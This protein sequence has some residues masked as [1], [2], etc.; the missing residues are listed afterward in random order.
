MTKKVKNL[1]YSSLAYRQNS[2]S[3]AICQTSEWGFWV[4]HAQFI[5][6]NCLCVV[7]GWKTLIDLVA[8]NFTIGRSGTYF[9]F[10][11]ADK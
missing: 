3:I 4:I 9:R 5:I 6:C 8:V 7:L 2:A 1:Q 10:T 11:L